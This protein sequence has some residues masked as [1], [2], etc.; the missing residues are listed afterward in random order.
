ME[1]PYFDGLSGFFDVLLTE[2]R[3][4]TVEKNNI[5]DNI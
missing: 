3:L 2:E 5:C 1:T 4:T